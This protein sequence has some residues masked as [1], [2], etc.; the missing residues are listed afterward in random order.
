MLSPQGAP[1]R[2]HRPSLHLNSS[3]TAN[4]L[5]TDARSH[6]HQGSTRTV[7]LPRAATN[8]GGTIAKSGD[9]ERCVVAGRESL[10]ILRVSDFPTSLN[11]DHKSSVG[12]GGHRIDASRNFWNGSG[13]KMESISTDVAW[14]LGSYDNKILTS[15]RNGELIMWDLNKLGPSK[16]ER[17]TRLHLRSIHV[18][19][20]SPIVF[21][22]CMTGSADGDIRVW[23]LRDM[24]NSVI[25]LHHPTAVRS[26]SFSR[27]QACPVHA[28]V[29]LDNGSLYRYDFSM[30]SKGQLDRLPVAHAAPI[31]TLDW[32]APEG[33]SPG[34]G[35]WVASG[36][37]DRTVKVWDLSGPQFERTPTYTLATP[38]PVRRVRWRPGYECELAVV[39]NAEFGTGSMSDMGDSGGVDG[40]L[41]EE[42]EAVPVK[43]RTDVGD[44]VE[45][46]DVRRGYIAKWLVGGSAIEGGVTDVEFR[47]SHALWAQHSSGTFAQ[48]DLRNSYRPLDAVP[49]LATAWD[50]SGSLAF[51]VDK[52]STWEIPYDD[53]EP[54][55]RQSVHPAKLKAL[56]DRPYNSISQSVGAHSFDPSHQ[57]LDRVAVLAKGYVFDNPD[58][59]QVCEMNAKVAL[60]A[61]HQ[62]AFQIWCLLQSLLTPT[63]PPPTRPPTPPL[64]PLPLTSRILPHSHSAPAAI[65]TSSS[66]T[67]NAPAPPDTPRGLP[68]DHASK[69]ISTH[70]STGGSPHRVVS[71]PVSNSP[72]PQRLSASQITASPQSALSTP[73]PNSSR[74]PSLFSR[75]PSN[76]GFPPNRPRALSSFRRL[77]ISSP[78]P[79]PSDSANATLTP[80]L[81]HVGEGTLDDSD[82][83]G[84]ESD[85]HEF[86][87]SASAVSPTGQSFAR[88]P[89]VHPSPLS[90]VAGQ[91]TWTEDEREADDD[92]PSPASTETESEDGSAP[93]RIRARSL[94]QRRR[95]KTR[96]RS[97]TLAAP[98]TPAPPLVKQG[99]RSSM[100]TV[101]AHD[102]ADHERSAAAIQPA[103]AS[104]VASRVASIG[105]SDGLFGSNDDNLLGP[106][107]MQEVW[108]RNEI[109]RRVEEVREA[110]WVALREALEECAGNGDVQTCA[111]MALVAPKDLRM[112][113]Q[114][115]K[116]FLEAYIEVLMR[117][118]LFTA[119]AYLRKH[120]PTPE[121]RAVTNLQTT[122]YI[123]C[124]RCGKLIPAQANGSV[125]ANCKLPA[126]QCSICHLPVKSMLFQCAICSHGGHQS[127]YRRFYTEKPMVA[128]LSPPPHSPVTPSKR[129]RRPGRST[130]RSND[131]EGDG[132]DAVPEYA[133]EPPAI[134]PAPRQ[135]VG[136]PCAAGCGH[137]CW[138]ANFKADIERT[139][140]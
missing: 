2:P 53:I 124:G 81:R 114:R 79:V 38:F 119:A 32:C 51:V 80:S 121:V 78:S 25:R 75:R 76:A 8:G 10:R 50:V 140:N 36:S 65:P 103:G 97:S 11:P 15:A 46:W 106:E 111:M 137:F 42:P 54:K 14:G 110:T 63:S 108:A 132:A 57:G 116:R 18:L 17:R 90:R 105:V 92:S 70:P 102:D 100:R 26:A 66:V 34:S 107:D 5:Y 138:A 39:S 71:N 96:S 59:V 31:L 123:S 58:K 67:A 99:S 130:S 118:K 82:S 133:P 73:S 30:G 21:N 40:V 20:Y 115:V 88:L 19:A 134:V 35:G 72:S 13:L 56:G 125:C 69:Q 60:E 84:S 37:L 4:D 16:Y 52:R 101:T 104:R 12:R 122:V 94:S 68:S 74:P 22:Y 86:L 112:S 120:A 131:S 23:D 45:I 29:G 61:N 24:R 43:R 113:E 89:L 93:K 126:A 83:S 129:P 117:M 98:Q 28:V 62:Q 91:Q 9:G 136:H 33:A 7:R 77:S 109:R 135:L 95:V 1:H 128:L 127:C 85:L 44:A 47:D 139:L 55:A 3:T 41:E 6:G 49:R 87:P 27:S 48:L 64:S